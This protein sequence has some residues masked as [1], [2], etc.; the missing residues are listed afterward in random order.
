MLFQRVGEILVRPCQRSAYHDLERQVNVLT[1][2][3]EDQGK[4][5]VK[6]GIS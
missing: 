1:Q 4:L 2:K 6:G 5:Q 3:G